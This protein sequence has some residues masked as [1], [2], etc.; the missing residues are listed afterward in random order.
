MQ[1]LGA[2]E[3]AG[4]VEQGAV[5]HVVRE[6]HPAGVVG[7]VLPGEPGGRGVVVGRV[8]LV[9]LVGPVRPGVPPHGITVR[10]KRV[11][12]AVNPGVAWKR[13]TR[14]VTDPKGRPSGHP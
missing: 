14:P 5:G 9:E 4:E 13:T 2:V 3:V 7:E 8:V 1:P 11:G 6:P 12:D 10:G